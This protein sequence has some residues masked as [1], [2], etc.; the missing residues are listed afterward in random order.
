MRR[1]SQQAEGLGLEDA[2]QDVSLNKARRRS[3]VESS[4]SDD[5]NDDFEDLEEQRLVHDD[6]EE[7]TDNLL[8]LDQ[9]TSWINLLDFIVDAAYFSVTID[10]WHVMKAFQVEEEFGSSR[11][12]DGMIRSAPI[13]YKS[14]RLAAQVLL[15][16][17]FV[18]MFAKMWLI[19]RKKE[20]D[21][22]MRAQA[23]SAQLDEEELDLTSQQ[24]QNL[25]TVF[26]MVFDFIGLYAVDLPQLFILY[27][28][29]NAVGSLSTPAMCVPFLQI[30]RLYFFVAKGQLFQSGPSSNSQYNPLMA[31]PMY[32]MLLSYYVMLFSLMATVFK[33]PP[34]VAGSVFHFITFTVGFLVVA[35]S[36]ADV[37][38]RFN[39]PL[40]GVLV[41]VALVVTMNS[42]EGSRGEVQSLAY[43][44]SYAFIGYILA[45]FS[46]LS[47]PMLKGGGR[48]LVVGW[49]RTM[50]SIR[51][52]LQPC[53]RRKR[54][55]VRVVTDS[56]LSNFASL[57]GVDWGGQGQ[58]ATSEQRWDHFDRCSSSKDFKEEYQLAEVIGRGA[59]S[60]VHE[61]KQVSTGDLVAVKCVYKKLLGKQAVRS[62]TQEVS[63]LQALRGKPHIVSMREFYHTHQVCY[64]VMDHCES[65]LLTKLVANKVHTERLVRK[66][67]RDV[68]SA[69]LICHN[70]NI[71]HR[72]LKPENLLA[73]R[74]VGNSK[75]DDMK[76]KEAERERERKQAK[77]AKKQA[78]KQS[79][80]QGEKNG[81]VAV[82]DDEPLDFGQGDSDTV[83]LADFG[84]AARVQNTK[85]HSVRFCGTL[86]FMAP[87]MQANKPHSLEADIWSL[88]VLSYLLL[89]GDLPFSAEE[90]SWRLGR[91]QKG[92]RVRTRKLSFEAPC[93]QVIS[94]EARQCVQSMMTFNPKKRPTVMQ[95]RRHPW[96]LQRETQVPNEDLPGV[97]ALLQEYQ[98]QY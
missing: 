31:L 64:L 26:S 95:V 7:Q 39:A 93:W 62:L 57:F 65:E 22:I 69:L 6:T 40:G 51:R 63:A 50:P 32:I 4:D 33:F 54:V 83:L 45:A 37:R 36:I 77:Q 72:D 94:M 14:I 82:E 75:F 10:T 60:V 55:V 20:F 97:Q 66:I 68:A 29:Y 9:A 21:A 1:P 88:G 44:M 76:M 38:P 90:I 43:V 13:A 81:A 92:G 28:V 70:E 85:I 80:G 67:I 87:E 79:G 5:A 74:T 96:F 89:C 98:D 30:G 24:F 84:L 58:Q 18:I 17:S 16:I 91:L 49:K 3:R 48:G 56:T 12:A 25:Y 52:L 27:V 53:R 2:K 78:A 59:F 61:A 46:S 8:K 86:D 71:V 23:K 42:M 41:L 19:V 73:R 11:G 34:E 47:L 15:A 35:V